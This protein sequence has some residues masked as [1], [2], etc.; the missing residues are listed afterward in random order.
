MNQDSK[1]DDATR[2]A[3]GEKNWPLPPKAGDIVPSLCGILRLR[4]SCSDWFRHCE[5]NASKVSDSRRHYPPMPEKD[6]DVLK[7]L[8]GHM[9]SARRH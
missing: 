5:W 2:L 7:V 3:G 1:I 6:A 9:A 8:I 4:L